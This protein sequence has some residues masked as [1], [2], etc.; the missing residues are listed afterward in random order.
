MIAGGRFIK[1]VA[2]II[3]PTAALCHSWERR[4][5][6]GLLKDAI[7]PHPLILNWLKDG[8]RRP[9]PSFPRKRESRRRQIKD[10]QNRGGYTDPPRF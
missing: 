9:L 4:R 3:P 8:L 1:D 6:S 5:F 10:Q 7:P 2:T